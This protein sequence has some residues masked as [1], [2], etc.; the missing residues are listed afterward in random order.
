M[1][2][3]WEHVGLSPLIVGAVGCEIWG[4]SRRSGGSTVRVCAGCGGSPCN[5]SSSAERAPGQKTPAPPPARCTEPESDAFPHS[6]ARAPDAA[7]LVLPSRCSPVRKQI[8]FEIL[9]V[10]SINLFKW[11]ISMNWW[12]THSDQLKCSLDI[13]HLLRKVHASKYITS[14]TYTQLLDI[15]KKFITWK[16]P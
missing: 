9:K 6:H 13:F 15:N 5:S 11:I 12:V 3:D 7:A 14:T 2:Q 10:I 16:M 1:L 8:M 4:F